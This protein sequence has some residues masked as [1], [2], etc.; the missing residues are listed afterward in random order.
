MIHD[1]VPRERVGFGFYRYL[2]RIH[3]T[4]NAQQ[5]DFLSRMWCTGGRA[6]FYRSDGVLFLLN[7]RLMVTTDCCGGRLVGVDWWGE[8]LTVLCVDGEPLHSMINRLR[9]GGG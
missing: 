5:M 7:N 8:S 2:K 1:A 6:A 3:V 4:A 9:L